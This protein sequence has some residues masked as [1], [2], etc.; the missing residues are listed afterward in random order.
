MIVGVVKEIKTHEYR[1]GLTP[2]GVRSLLS[3]GAKGVWVQKGAGLGS[4]IEDTQFVDSGAIIKEDAKTIWNQ[5]DM[6]VKVKEPIEQEFELMKPGQIL[7]TFLHLAILPEL[8]GVLKAKKIAAIGYETIQDDMGA[9][10]LLKPMSE[11]AGKMAI[12][13]GASFLQSEKG[14]RGVLLGGVPG[15]PRGKVLILGAGVV[16]TNACKVA[17][18]MGSQVVVMDKDLKRLAYLDDI[19]GQKITTL[20]SSPTRIEEQLKDTDLLIGGVLIP[21]AK[22]PKLV[23]KEMIKIMPKG[24]VIVDVAVD[25]GGCVETCKPTSHDQ[26]TYKVD[27]VIHYCVTNIP[28]AV[29]S[30]STFALTNVTYTYANE[31]VAKGLCKAIKENKMLWRGVNTLNGEITHEAVA[32]GLNMNH[33][34][35]EKML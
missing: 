1:V 18:G 33:V 24:S 20:Y 10:P 7:Y 25:Q 28:G 32:T 22:A 9:L 35:L 13:I 26:P 17:V 29:A 31:I 27:D 6:I 5:A 21:G 19:F 2:A 30:T 3:S 11:V 23:S 16:G 15:V 4:G 12:Q 8:A 14:G 34:T